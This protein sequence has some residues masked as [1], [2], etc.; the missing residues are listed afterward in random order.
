MP[1]V[2]NISET[3]VKTLP[4]F[5]PGDSVKV[6]Q[7]IKEGG[8]ERVQVFE[9]LVIA[10][11]GGSGVNATFM[12]RKISYGVGVERIFPLHSPNIAQL[13]V[14]KSPEVRRAKL[15]YVRGRQ[16]NMPTMRKNKTVKKLDNK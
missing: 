12:V 13:E 9:G 6:H 7:K 8:K 3:Q 10:K 15:Y 1:I 4:S 14:V 16:D 11:K 5:K 2:K